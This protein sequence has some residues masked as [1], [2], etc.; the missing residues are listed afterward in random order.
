MRAITTNAATQAALAQGQDPIIVIKIDWPAP[1]GTQWYGDEDVDISPIHVQGKLLVLGTVS[2]Q[3][4]VDQV[5]SAAVVSITLDD[6]D[7]TLKTVIDN[8]EVEYATVTIY[9]WFEGLT[10]ADLMTV[11]EGNICGPIE[12]SEG[13]R[14][15]KFDAEIRSKDLEVGFSADEFQAD[16]VTPSI[17]S[18]NPEAA[19]K[20]WPLCFGNVV[21]VPAL[22]LLTSPRGH[23]LYPF[24]GPRDPSQGPPTTPYFDDQNF[25]LQSGDGDYFPQGSEIQV[26]I[27]GVV[28]L[29]EF[30]GDKFNVVEANYPKYQALPFGDR[31]VNL[32]TIPGA[33]PDLDVNN[34][35]V[36]WLAQPI[37]I[38]N[39]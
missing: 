7:G 8:N 26:I 16:N 1:Y 37:S 39:N 5:S 14:T 21:L 6:S 32:P 10:F 22:K 24:Q 35:R 15:F 25:T 23:L 18:L 34:H 11:F 2:C 20:A 19:D 27:D 3:V 17:P 31:G 29:G 13:Q 38:V 12:W 9:Q 28:F 36:A 30:H 4:T 33:L